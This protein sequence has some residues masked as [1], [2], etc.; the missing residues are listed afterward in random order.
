MK[1]YQHIFFDLDHTLWD[2]DSNV[3]DTLLELF[4]RH[5]LAELGEITFESFFEAFLTTNYE[6]WD[7]FN[8][9]KVNQSDMRKIR[10]IK[11]FSRAKLSTDHIP[12]TFEKDFV[13]QTSSRSKVMDHTFEILDYLSNAYAL[14]IITNGFNDSQYAKLK[15]SGLAPYFK[16]IVTSESSGFRKPDKRIFVHALEKLGSKP[17]DCLMIGDNP[18]SDILGARNAA[19]DQVYYNPRGITDPVQSTFTIRHLSELRA[20]L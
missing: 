18:N 9:G 14:H 17:D 6:L 2:Y 12:S 4:A 13:S 1:K 5:R 10:F 3:R 8:R 20:I 16:L 7:L 19:I 11:V 15:Y